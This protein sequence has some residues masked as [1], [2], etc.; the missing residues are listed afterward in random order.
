MTKHYFKKIAIFLVITLGVTLL[1]SIDKTV[2]ADNK[3]NT[4]VSEN[5][6]G[7]EEASIVKEI[8]ELREEY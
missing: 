7:K 5:N 3:L 4:M 1:P 8:E 6:S 2:F